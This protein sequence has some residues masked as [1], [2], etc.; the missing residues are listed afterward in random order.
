MGLGSV[1]SAL[2]SSIGLTHVLAF[3]V[4]F[5]TAV[6]WLMT[7]R[8]GEY[9]AYGIKSAKP[10]FFFGNARP[11]LAQSKSL[12]DFHRDIYNEFSNEK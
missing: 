10:E 7:R 6:Y 1:L 12:M 8:F 4:I 11:L 2:F 3:V 9:E 5:L